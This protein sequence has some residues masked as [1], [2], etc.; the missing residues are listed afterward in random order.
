MDRSSSGLRALVFRH[1]AKNPDRADDLSV[2][3]APCRR[4][5]RRRRDFARYAAGVQ[6]NVARDSLIRHLPKR[7]GELR[8]FIF[9][10]KTR[11]A[12]ISRPVRFQAQELAGG[13]IGKKNIGIE[14]RD[15]ERVRR[16]LDQTFGSFGAN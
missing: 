12:G 8:D 9:G 2:G 7:A 16:V 10:K 1:I 3:T 14:I 15:E 13:V 5:E 6:L 4:I 11:Q